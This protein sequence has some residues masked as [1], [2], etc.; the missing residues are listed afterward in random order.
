[1]NRALEKFK[2]GL[3]TFDKSG[4]FT[5]EDYDA[6]QTLLASALR[7]SAE[8]DDLLDGLTGLFFE[9]HLM[10]D[11]RR[12]DLIALH[13]ADLLRA[14]RTRFRQLLADTHDEYEPFHAL[15][16][17]VREVL[18]ILVRSHE[19]R[20][21]ASAPWPSAIREKGHFSRALITEACAAYW[22]EHGGVPDV[23]AAT[24]QIHKRY[25]DSAVDVNESQDPPEVLQRRLDGQR[26][27]AGI[28]ELLSAEE[29]DL[30]KHVLV[31]E[32]SVEEWATRVGVSRATAYRHMAGLKALCRL[33]F[34]QR[35]N[36]TQLEALAALRGQL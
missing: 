20:P 10:N 21:P 11:V 17:H 36:R 9:R 4:V 34:S 5:D 15:R 32:G 30:L 24:A 19:G 27:A 3:R 7:R 35:S 6:L 1:M 26:L 14:L 31:E 22:H 18:P 29:K 23:R 33:E 8:K 12:R 25:A 16:S 28:L 2:E 13:D